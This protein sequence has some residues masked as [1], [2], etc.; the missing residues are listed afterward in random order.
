MKPKLAYY[1][2]DSGQEH[3][4]NGDNRL[5]VKD[6]VCDRT[7]GLTKNITEDFIELQAG[8]S[9]TDL[10]TVFIAGEHIGEIEVVAH[11][12]QSLRISGEGINLGFIKSYKKRS[13]IHLASLR[14]VL[15]I[16]CCLL[17]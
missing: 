16:F 17:Y 4:A 6:A 11:L 8:D 5:M 7:G 12:S 13:Q 3:F 2:L 14:A 1:V 15:F 9:Q 10:C